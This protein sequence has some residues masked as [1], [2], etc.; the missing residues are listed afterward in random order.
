[1]NSSLDIKVLLSM[2]LESMWIKSWFSPGSSRSAGNFPIIN[3][4]SGATNSRSQSSF[5]A[6]FRSAR[7]RSISRNLLTE[8]SMG[9]ASLSISSSPSTALTSRTIS[10]LVKV[11]QRTEVPQKLSS[12]PLVL[13]VKDLPSM[14]EINASRYREIVSKGSFSAER[15]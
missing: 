1:M 7:H 5:S 12:S 4:A 15:C 3:R 14:A 6:F 10:T 13:Q 11:S 9:S 8:E 2:I